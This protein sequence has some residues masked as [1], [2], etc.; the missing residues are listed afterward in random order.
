MATQTGLGIDQIIGDK[1]EAILRLAREYRASN[2][3]VF[4]SV[5][6]GEAT[7][8]SDLD[9]LVTFQTNYTFWDQIGLQQDIET[10]IGRKVEV[11]H[12]KFLRE[13]FV[14]YVM[15]DIVPL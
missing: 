7:S 6:R 4:G 15:P 5:A 12:D 3:R 1:R 8:K 11:I 2:I 14:P 10:L 13:E 9:L